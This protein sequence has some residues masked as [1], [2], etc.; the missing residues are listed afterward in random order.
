[1]IQEYVAILATVLNQ[2]QAKKSL[3]DTLP[4]SHLSALVSQDIKEMHVSFL[5]IGDAMIAV[6]PVCVLSSRDLKHILMLHTG[7]AGWYDKGNEEG[8]G[9]YVQKGCSCIPVNQL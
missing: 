1:M 4:I 2:A 6:A 7:G 5:A 9:W 3:L 8:C